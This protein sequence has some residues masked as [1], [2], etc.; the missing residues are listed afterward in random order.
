LTGILISINTAVTAAVL[1]VPLVADLKQDVFNLIRI[2]DR[3][4]VNNEQG[5]VKILEE[6]RL[7]LNRNRRPHCPVFI[8][9]M[10]S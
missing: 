9:I 1:N 5:V 3:V 7:Y 8:L 4:C 2:G 10:P 6:N